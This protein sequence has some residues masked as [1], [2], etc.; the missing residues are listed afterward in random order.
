MKPSPTVVAWLT[1]NSVGVLL[2]LI[3][4]SSAWIE[5]ELA[6]VPGASG[7]AAFGWFATAVPVFVGF[8][9]A[10]LVMAVKAIRAIASRRAWGPLLALTF[11]A[12]LWAWTLWFDNLHHGI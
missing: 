8:A 2:F 10:H 11:T 3:L 12:V 7:G 9:I 1:A 5:P 4:A 6:N